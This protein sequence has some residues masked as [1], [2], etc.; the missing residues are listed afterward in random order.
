MNDERHEEMHPETSDRDNEYLKFVERF[1]PLFQNH[2]A[3]GNT[4]EECRKLLPTKEQFD[5]LLAE[6]SALG[7]NSYEKPSED[8]DWLG[9]TAGF[10]GCVDEVN[11][12]GAVLAREF[13]PTR[14]ELSIIATYWLKVVRDFH[15]DWFYFQSTDSVAIRREPFA[16]RRLGRI[17]RILG[18]EAMQEL[19]QK[20]TSELEANVDPRLWKM[21]VT[22]QKPARDE[23]GLPILPNE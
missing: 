14:H 18:E 7:E 5:K 22:G 2:L 13:V 4:P 16:R 10:I 1:I 8:S 9:P 11:G 6:L 19:N 21:F 20:V 12:P 15:F 17:E 23:H 3:P